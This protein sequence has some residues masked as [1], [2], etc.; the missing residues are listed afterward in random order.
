MLLSLLR[1][2]TDPNPEADQGEIPF[3]Y[4]LVP[5]EGTLAET[6]VVKQAYYLNYPMAALP[7]AGKDDVLPTAYSAL[8][9]DRENVIC[10]TVK[11]A[12]RGEGTVLRLYECKNRRTK[13][14]MQLGLP[15]RQ[16]FLCDMM[17]RELRELPVVD[18]RVE[19]TLSGF[20]IVTLKVKA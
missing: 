12:E 4:A 7:T 18:G 13:T 11:Q 2:P 6:D 14:T 16:V 3:T 20:E 19:L 8:T 10:E 15:V 1:S 9:L 5:H 17:E